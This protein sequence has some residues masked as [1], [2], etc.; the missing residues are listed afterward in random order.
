[1]AVDSRMADSRVAGIDWREGNYGSGGTSRI[2]CTL[3]SS[4][5]THLEH[6]KKGELYTYCAKSRTYVDN[7]MYISE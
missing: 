7:T 3:S 4:L 2:C 1:M 6:Q 5:T